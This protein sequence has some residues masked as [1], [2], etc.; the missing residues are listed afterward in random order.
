MMKGKCGR[1]KNRL[2]LE[3]ASPS[4]VRDGYGRCRLCEN[5]HTK[6]RSL[7]EFQTEDR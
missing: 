4:V 6:K 3:N 5:E 7:L 1:C 2:T